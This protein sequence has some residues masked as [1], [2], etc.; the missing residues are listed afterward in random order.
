MS[1]EPVYRPQV[2]ASPVPARTSVLRWVVTL[3]IALAAVAAMA[4][5]WL[6]W[7][8]WNRS[9]AWVSEEVSQALGRPFAIRGPLDL[10]W[11]WPQQRGTGWRR[12]IPGPTVHAHD[13]LIGNPP[14][15]NA[16][17]PHFAHIGG[18]TADL[19]LLPLLARRIEIRRVALTE[20]D[21][22]L[23]R[24][25]D[26]HNNW[27]L[28]LP[29]ADADRPRWSVDIGQVVLS[30]GRLGYDDA[31]RQLSVAGSLDTL[32]PEDSQDGRYGVGFEFTGWQGKAQIRGSGKAGQLLSLK[33]EQLDFP[34]QLDA[35]A[36]RV[37]AKAE[38]II[39]NPRQL[40][41]VDF[42]VNLRGGSLA[43]L[44]P[45]TGIVLPD[46]P[47]FATQGHLVGTLKQGAAV[48]DYQKFTGTI[49]HSDIAGDVTY[50]SA[51]P[52]PRLKGKLHS[53][54]LRLADLGPVV[55][56]KSN[57]PDRPKRAGK[58]LPDDPFDTTRWDKM[59]LDLVYTGQRVE[60]PEA[61][62]INSLNVHAL[63]D[64][65]QL[66]LAPLDFGVAGGRFKTQVQMN[67]GTKPMAV[68]L[69]GDVQG[70]KLSA[71]FPKVE[72]MK[73]SLGRVDGGIAFDA[74]G[75]SIARMAA[76]AN[77][78]ARLYV[79][80][81]VMSQQLLDLAGLNL[82]SVVVA[83]LFGTDKEVRLR[84]AIADV[85]VR[86]GVAHLR[87][88][89]INTDDALI[90]LTGTANLRDEM[91]DIDVNPK[92]YELKLFSLRTPLEVKGPFAKPHVG[93]KAG[94]LIVR[95]AAAVAAL[96]V[97]PGA[98][99]LVPITVPGA[100]DDESCAPLLAQGSKAPKAGRPTSVAA[101]GS[102]A[103]SAAAPATR[104]SAP[105]MPAAGEFS[106]GA[107]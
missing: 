56:A 29:E 8:D 45:L 81:G 50:T 69:R 67:P 36:G 52:R 88:V 35:R 106:G 94:P 77:G 34:L 1:P 21:V 6:T 32:K 41:G 76:T 107:R 16:R 3:L 70:L 73:K 92:A 39:A 101:P 105:A 53:R 102:A 82:G 75:E 48:W 20:P 33:D 13:V 66:K 63:L 31:P 71:L 93:V 19:A 98:L 86:D 79:R 89:K 91:L 97:A 80:D 10:D 96:A 7:N 37:A 22:R 87:N 24:Q 23:E 103:A 11:E 104:P 15:F 42:K 65:G 61:V 12:W 55:G 44:Y 38:G 99:A 30:K 5:A 51:E 14:D 64:G 57:N 72:L 2:S 43:D 28:Q 25:K 4:L 78:E 26:G 40:S 59:D 68:S 49:G 90:D 84:C 74:R 47:E 60:R 17:A 27:T 58:V 18:V 85:P 100:E 83:K 9:R 46:T 54:L 95:A 62:P